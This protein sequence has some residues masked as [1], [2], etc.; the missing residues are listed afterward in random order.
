[1]MCA[2]V[3]DLRCGR[4]AMAALV[5]RHRNVAR[6]RQGYTTRSD[7]TSAPLAL[8]VPILAWIPWRGPPQTNIINNHFK[9]MKYCIY[10][11]YI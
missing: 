10:G 8:E 5:G 6:W 2:F 9:N 1:M 4:V 7:D 3:F 11:I